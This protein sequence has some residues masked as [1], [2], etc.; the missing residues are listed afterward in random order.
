MRSR[1]LQ[2]LDFVKRY[3]AQWGYSP[4][5]S[6]IAA[7]LDVSKKR[8]RELINQLAR[9]RMIDVVAGKHRGIILP[10]GGEISEAEVLVRLARAGWA[11][12]CEDKSLMPPGAAPF[13]KKGLLTL[14]FLDHKPDATGE[15]SSDGV[16]SG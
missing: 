3:F 11:I 13:P 5:H 12:S 16:Q 4:S 9:E 15:G 14:P 7:E 6:E 10:E 2:A 8:V 1:K